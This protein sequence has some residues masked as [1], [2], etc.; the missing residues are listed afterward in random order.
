M[1]TAWTSWS[2]VPNRSAPR[3]VQE[4]S[5][6]PAT[7]PRHGGEQP[8]EVVARALRV[9]H[10]QLHGPADRDDVADDEAVPLRVD[11]DHAADQEVAE[12]VLVGVLVH[13]DAELQAAA[14]QRLLGGRELD[15]QLLELGRRGPAGEPEQHVAV[16]CSHRHRRPDRP[17]ALADERH[18]RDVAAEHH[19]HGAA[20][21]HDAVDEQPRRA[22][23]AQPDRVGRR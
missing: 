17:A 9:A 21:A 18:R 14:D 12:T 15:E 19:A 8:V 6:A 1:R 2:A 11:T 16:G 5:S 22:G 13:G 3:P 20:V 4:N 7:S 10:L 23:A